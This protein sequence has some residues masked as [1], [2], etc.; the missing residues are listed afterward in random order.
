MM[1]T[2]KSDSQLS[3]GRWMPNRDSSSP[4]SS[5]CFKTL[6]VLE[7]VA[8]ST[9][10]VILAHPI[11]GNPPLIHSGTLSDPTL[12]RQVPQTSTAWSSRT[13]GSTRIVIVTL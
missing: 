13:M 11:E 4:V 9:K 12:A 6:G 10:K 5:A 3:Q 1:M 8:L 2:R 7:K